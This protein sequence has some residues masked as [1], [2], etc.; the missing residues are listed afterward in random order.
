MRYDESPPRN[1]LQRGRE[2]Q[3]IIFS[4]TRYTSHYTQGQHKRRNISILNILYSFYR[5]IDRNIG[6]HIRYICTKGGGGE[7][8]VY[9]HSSVFNKLKREEIL[10]ARYLLRLWK[11]KIFNSSVHTQ[12]REVKFFNS[13]VPTQVKEVKIF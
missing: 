13:S 1:N 12:V 5:V 2:T 11:S 6:S 7:V 9:T 8:R 4:L 3:I 10:T